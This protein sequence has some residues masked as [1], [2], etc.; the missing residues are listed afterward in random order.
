MKQYAIIL[1]AMFLIVFQPASLCAAN[2]TTIEK[3][4]VIDSLVEKSDVIVQARLISQQGEWKNGA[5]VTR[6]KL[7]VREDLSAQGLSEMDLLIPGGEAVHP[8]LKTKVRTTYSHGVQLKNDQELLV[9]AKKELDGSY[10]LVDHTKSFM[11][12]SKN[13]N[14]DKVLNKLQFLDAGLTEP[15]LTNQELINISS[16]KNLAKK[17]Q[18]KSNI[19]TSNDIP[20]VTMNKKSADLIE[21]KKRI[22]HL[23]KNRTNQLEKQ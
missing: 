20:K 5:I 1:T 16:D 12:I 22:R 17:T 13:N 8:V 11:T 4:N 21:V 7:M 9:F 3:S 2:K 14:N 15:E 18:K 19:N 10:R 23:V 6:I